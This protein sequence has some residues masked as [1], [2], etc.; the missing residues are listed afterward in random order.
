MRSLYAI[1]ERTDDQIQTTRLPLTAPNYRRIR[2]HEES[3]QGGTRV[4]LG[5]QLRRG[6]W[7]YFHALGKIVQRQC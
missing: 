7:P 3:V 4:D 1:N 5:I 2:Q 6:E